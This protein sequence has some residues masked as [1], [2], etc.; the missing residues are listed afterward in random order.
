ME[1]SNREQTAHVIRRLGMGGNPIVAAGLESPDDAVTRALD[2]SSPATEV[3]PLE[4]PASFQAARDQRLTDQLAWWVEAMT[5]GER[6][7]EE[8]LVWFWTD[9]FATSR[10][11]VS[12]AYLIWQQHLTI[13]EHATGSFTDLLHAVATDPA[14]LVYL[15]G[16]TNAKAN[17]NENF[18]REVMELYTLGVGNY[19]Q[20]DVVEAG[21][22]F[23]GWVINVPSERNG[24]D[25][26]G[27][28]IG[29]WQS[30]LVDRRHDAGSKTILGSTA[31]H[32][33]ASTIELLLDQ[34]STAEHIAA[35]MFHELV[36][37]APSPEVVRDLAA[38][39]RADYQIMPLVSSIVSRPEFLSDEAIRA[40][41]R[42][43]LE[44]VITLM[45]A[46]PEQQTLEG[47]AE[48]LRFSGYVP[49][50]PPNPAGYAE[51]TELLGPYLLTHTLDLLWLIPQRAE[52]TTSEA[53]E[54]LGIYD[55]SSSTIAVLDGFDD[56]LSKLASALASPEFIL[57]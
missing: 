38:E 29:K 47:L 19:S 33:M 3:P 5:S 25:L 42:T 57:T 55:A 53:L 32:G 40:R 43:P 39:F 7:I 12:A 11:K 45:Q 9:H 50:L 14:M 10:R 51:G 31:N 6:I 2:L 54:R 23:T 20:E 22:A 26:D 34:P 36:G 27:L 8:R 21:R 30:G 46:F 16:R 17:P 15:D 48:I 35:K 28:G 1:Y 44:K 4:P 18:G 49:F 37:I 13:R 24:P 52:V 41:V 56:P